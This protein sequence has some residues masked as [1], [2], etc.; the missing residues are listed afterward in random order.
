MTKTE[1]KMNINNVDLKKHNNKYLVLARN[2]R[3]CRLIGLKL[4]W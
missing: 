4:I 1:I 3:L 2:S